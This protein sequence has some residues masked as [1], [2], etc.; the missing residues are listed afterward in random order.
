MGTHHAGNLLSL[1]RQGLTL[2]VQFGPHSVEALL[3]VAETI[4]EGVYEAGSLRR[5]A[6]GIAFALDN[7]L[8]RVGAFASL[9]VRVNGEPVSGARVRFRPGAGT[10]WRTAESVTSGSSF[11]LAPGDRTEVEVDGR[12]GRPGDPVTVRIELRTP[13]IPPRVWL[14]FTETATDA[15]RP[16]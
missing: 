9:A 8:L 2:S 15:E 13:A 6:E 7:P 1:V 16:P 11:S 5:T 10:P 3:W 12:F 14:E 4:E